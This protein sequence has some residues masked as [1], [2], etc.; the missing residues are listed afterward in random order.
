LKI[1]DFVGNAFNFDLEALFK[2]V[3]CVHALFV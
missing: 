2:L 3:C 1:D